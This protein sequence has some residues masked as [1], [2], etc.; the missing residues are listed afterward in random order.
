MIPIKTV[1]E[2]ILWYLAITFIYSI[3]IILFILNIKYNYYLLVYI[4]SGILAFLLLINAIVSIY[5]HYDRKNLKLDFVDDKVLIMI[6]I[7]KE[8]KEV[9]KNTIDSIKNNL[10]INLNKILI[11]FIIDG[12][13][14]YHFLEDSNF[15]P[16]LINNNF[17]EYD[18][19]LLSL[20]NGHIYG[21][22]YISIFKSIRKGKKNSHCIIYEIFNDKLDLFINH[23]YIIDKIKSCKYLLILDADTIIEPYAIN[24]FVNKLKNKNDLIAITGTTEVLN[25]HESFTACGQVFE[26]F[27]SHILLKSFE[28]YVFNCLVL[29]GCFTMLKVY[30]DNGLDYNINVEFNKKPY[31]DEFILEQYNKE[32]NSLIENN[33]FNF[34]EDRFLTI[35]LLKKYINNRIMYTNHTRCYTIVPTTIISL[36]KQR[37]RWTNSLVFC[38]IYVLF[39]K[40]ISFNLYFLILLQ[41]FIT[42][43]LPL[44]IILC[45]ISIITYLLIDGCTVIFTV[46]TGNLILYNL[47][48]TIIC[49]EFRMIGYWFIFLIYSL[50]F[51]VIIPLI[52]ILKVNYYIW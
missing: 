18:N 3:I 19:N 34:G 33:M 7:Y 9:I 38:H 1:F 32:P 24:I 14:N 50:L 12:N 42:I 37:I 10:R 30:N 29:S 48:V 25:K 5:F 31:V 51:S 17:I 11:V 28:T 22:E 13:E 41:L 4:F 46:I 20:N 39:G 26:Y 45:L 2:T 15:Q 16:E 43:I 6:T 36:I 21:I 44:L 27:N 52:S 47:Y 8:D 49:C 35:L 23:L 40:F